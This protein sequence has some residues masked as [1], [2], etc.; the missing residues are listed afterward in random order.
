MQEVLEGGTDTVAT[1]LEWIMSELLRHPTAMETL[2]NE[3]RG[4]AKGREGISDED[5]KKMHYLKA[6]IKES[7]RLHPPAALLAPRVVKKDVR[8]KDYDVPKGAVVMVNI[9]AIGRDPLCWDEPEKFKP[10]RFLDCLAAS[11]ETNFGW[12]PFGAGRRGCPG[13]TYSMATIEPL[14]ANI[15]QKFDW[16]LPNG[17][18]LDMGERSGLATHRAIPLLAFA[19]ETT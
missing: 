13:G 12:I 4:V 17:V 10:E 9:W 3:V 14:I 8:V 2:Q 15:V 18:E 6:V 1:A 16:K 5:I 19:S 7:L 11:K